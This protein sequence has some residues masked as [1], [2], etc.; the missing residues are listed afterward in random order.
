MVY[1]RSEAHLVHLIR[2]HVAP[3]THIMTDGW[4][5]YQNLGSMGYTHSVVIHGDHFV[6]PDNPLIHTQTIEV[7]WCSLKRFIRAHETYKGT[8]YIEYIC[9][10]LFR[11]KFTN[12]FDGL[13]EVIQH[14]NHFY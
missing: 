14:N 3:G 4:A 5:A 8:H 11:R 13:L 9:E 2:C 6:S 7:T 10:Y 1:D 12:V